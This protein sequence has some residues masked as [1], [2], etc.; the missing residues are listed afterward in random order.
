VGVTQ[1]LMEAPTTNDAANL[2]SSRTFWTLTLGSVGVVYGDIGTSPLYA[3]REAL[4][5]AIGGEGRLVSVE[6]VLGVLSLILWALT[7]IVTAKYV[8]ILLRADN[9]VKVAYCR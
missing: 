9:R 6:V 2:R 7:I 1:F 3:F 4:N 8:F 5:A